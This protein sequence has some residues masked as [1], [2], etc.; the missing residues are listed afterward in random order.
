MADFRLFLPDD[1]GGVMGEVDERGVLTFFICAAAGSPIRGTELFYLMMRAFGDRVRAVQGVWRRGYGGSPSVNLDRVNER[2]AAGASL[3]SA[4][5]ATWTYTRAA[6]WGF[7]RATPI[8]VEG[9]PG[10]YTKIDVLLEKVG[11]AP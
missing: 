5:R 11:E 3:M 2:T 4:V 7:T 6:R 8:G 10:S 9:T 1:A